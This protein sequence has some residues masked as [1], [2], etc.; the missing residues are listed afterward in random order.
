MGM[1]PTPMPYS[2]VF[3]ALQQGVV[4]GLVN[5]M[6]TFYQ[7]KMYE[8]GK[9]LSISDQMY[10]VMPMM[11]SET[12]FQSLPGDQQQALLDAASEAGR[13]WRAIYPADDRKYLDQLKEKGLEINEVKKDVFRE[14]VQK[15]YDRY[16]EV[17]PGGKDLI[18]ELRR[19]AQS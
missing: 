1:N 18:A 14:H 11:I 4:D 13:Y 10:V 2:E 16:L 9:Y 8:V 3:T 19:F 17:V 6:T 12:V 5:S 15:Q 7:T